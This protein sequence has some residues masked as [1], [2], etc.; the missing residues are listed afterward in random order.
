MGNENIELD[1]QQIWFLFIRQCL[2]NM[3]ITIIKGM[4][5][6]MTFQYHELYAGIMV[7][8][9]EII[10]VTPNTKA[11]YQIAFQ[12]ADLRDPSVNEDTF[13]KPIKQQLMAWRKQ[14]KEDKDDI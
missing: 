1:D 11:N 7:C 3:G 13:A 2:E 14:H 8:E 10:M 9:K 12:F 4:P 6:V 5:P